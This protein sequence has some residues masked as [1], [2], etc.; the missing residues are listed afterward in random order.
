MT[1]TSRNGIL[2][3]T[4]CKNKF[5]L[6][7][8]KGFELKK[9]LAAN[10]EASNVASGNAKLKDKKNFAED[11]T[12]QPRGIGSGVGS[13]L[14]IDEVAVGFQAALDRLVAS[15]D[16][17]GRNF[18]GGFGSGGSGGSGK[19]FEDSPSRRIPPKL[20]RIG[21]M[22]AYSGV[23]RQT[24]HNYT[25]MGLISE[26]NWT[27]GGHRLY[28]EAAFERL[29]RIADLRGQRRSMDYIRDYLIRRDAGEA[30]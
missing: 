20:Y 6:E 2:P 15:R 29:D 5:A 30:V 17:G 18:G 9:K 22:V 8:I 7:S 27:R 21:E 11:T 3:F 19:D 16:R 24:I 28:D 4:K 26:S 12:T 1:E 23:S 13:Q 10:R 25:T 14:D